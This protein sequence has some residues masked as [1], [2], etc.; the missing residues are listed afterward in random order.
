M[1][2]MYA[3][4]LQVSLE[5]VLSAPDEWLALFVG[6]G[7]AAVLMY[8]TETWQG[9]AVGFVVLIAGA[10]PFLPVDVIL[11]WHYWPA[12]PVAV[13]FLGLYKWGPEDPV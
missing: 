9:Y 2:V 12:V 11:E 1:V 3:E 13:F 7:L 4:A 10:F 5:T 8:L 6:A